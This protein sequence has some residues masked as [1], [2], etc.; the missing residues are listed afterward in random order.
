MFSKSQN[1]LLPNLVW[2]CS[3][4]C[5]SVLRT[6]WF[7]LAIFKVKATG[8]AHMTKIWLSTIFSELLIPGQP[9][10]VW[11]YIILSLS[12]LWKKL[13][14]CIHSQGHSEGQNVYVCLDD[15]FHTTQHFVSKLGI[16]MHHYEP[17][18]PA[19]RFIC[20]FQGQGHCKSSYDQNM[21]ISTVSFELLT[22]LVLNFVWEC[23]IINQIVLL[24][25]CCVQGQGHSKTSK[26]RWMC[27][28]MIP[29]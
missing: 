1:I 12:V 23:I 24:R 14:Y 4:V 21:T 8:R 2:W 5:Q 25:N 7:C 20:Y 26:C 9:D 27:V 6:N 28:Q 11:W 18:C 3:I 19:E 17:E 13:N 10:L 29:S 15:I 22:L 16:T